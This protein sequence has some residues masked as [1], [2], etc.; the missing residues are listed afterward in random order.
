[1]MLNEP[2]AETIA[3]NL[4]LADDDLLFVWTQAK[5]PGDIQSSLVSVGFT[6]TEVFAKMEENEAALRELLRTELKFK[7]GALLQKKAM[8]GRVVAAW[9]SAQ[10]RGTKRKAEEALQRAT[11]APRTL[12]RAQHL[13]IIRAFSRGHDHLPQ[14]VHSL[15][16]PRVS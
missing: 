6:E 14:L 3:A 16:V 13:S 12:P 11:D 9:E 1:M 15:A 7:E 5:I 4:K 8:V 2:S 10:I